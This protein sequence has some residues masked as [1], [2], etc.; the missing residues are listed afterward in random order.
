MERDAMVFP[1]PGAAQSMRLSPVFMRPSRRGSLGGR[2]ALSR[3]A[4]V[5]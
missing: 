5:R 1:T 4:S 2:S 3:D